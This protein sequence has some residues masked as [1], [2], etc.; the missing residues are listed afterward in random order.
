MLLNVTAY[1]LKGDAV[2]P[3]SAVDLSPYR[4]GQTLRWIAPAGQWRVAVVSSQTMPK[5][6]NPLN[7]ELGNRYVAKYFQQFENLCPGESG[8]G[9]DFFWHDGEWLFLY[10]F[11]LTLYWSRQF[12]GEF[13]KRKGYDIVPV[14]PALF[15]DIGPRTPKIR[16]DYFDVSV[17]LM[18]ESFFRPIFDW[19]YRRGMLYCVD[20]SGRG[21]L[22]NEFGDYFRTHR[23]YTAPGHD[24]HLGE[25]RDAYSVKNKV[26]SSIAH[27]YQRPRTFLEGFF[28]TGWG[29]TPSDLREHLANSLMLGSNLW[30]SVCFFYTQYGGWWEF[31]T[32]S[33][34]FRA[35]YA[36]H[37]RELTKWYERLAYLLSQGVHRC[38]VAVVYPVAP[39]QASMSKE[40]YWGAYGCRRSQPQCRIRHCSTAF[41]GGHRFRFYRLPIA[42]TIQDAEQGAVGFWRN[43]SSPGP[44]SPLGSQLFHN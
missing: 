1:R 42:G 22:P 3:G 2:V 15:S 31:A 16:L 14:L 18:E 17:S 26:G 7:H 12:A 43:V 40:L 13:Q 28:G 33:D 34:D 32:A 20:Q 11:G 23:W 29:N 25:A 44:A 37:R 10:D 21:G 24:R 6:W 27:L 5:S 8:K 19:H 39:R 4:N 38:D 30:S 35:P 36:P 41:D 9:L